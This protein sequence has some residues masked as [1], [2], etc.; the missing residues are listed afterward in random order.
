[1]ADIQVNRQTVISFPNDDIDDITT[2]IAVGSLV[3]DEVLW[4]EGFSIGEANANRF[5]AEV[6]NIDD[7]SGKDI[8]V[9]QIITSGSDETIEPLFTGRVD[10]CKR[11][12][13]RQD[14]ARKLVAYDA[15][16]YLSDKNVAEWW[17]SIFDTAPSITLGNM[18]KSLCTYVGLSYDSTQTLPNDSVA[19]TQTQQINSIKFIDVLKYICI[20]QCCTA[21]ISRTGAIEFIT[22]VGTTHT[23]QD[24]EYE[25]NNSEFE[26]YLVPAID[27]VKIA[28]SVND[29]EVTAGT[30]RK[31][32]VI[33]DNLLVLNKSQQDLQVIANVIL[34]NLPTLTYNPATVRMILSDHDVKVGDV[35]QTDTGKTLICE[36]ELSGSML[37]EQTCIGT[38]SESYDENS[39]DGYKYDVTEQELKKNISANETKYYRLAN[40]DAISV[41][42]N[43]MRRILSTRYAVTAQ[44]L[45]IFQGVVILDVTPI[46]ST[47]PFGVEIQYEVLGEIV[48]TFTPTETYIAGR[49]TFNLLYFW[50]S[51]A[52]VNDT[53]YVLLTTTNCAVSIGA[54]RIKAL[55]QGI[56]LL[57]DEVWD[58]YIDVEDTIGLIDITRRIEFI[59]FTDDLEV[60][61]DEPLTADGEETVGLID[62]T[63]RIDFI[64]FEDYVLVDKESLFFGGYTW[65]DVNEMLWAT[66]HD[67]YTW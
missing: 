25:V 30:G 6:Y 57:G 27:K 33:Q 9:Y 16:Y 32:I 13:M 19:I 61:I 58:G 59:S 21:N 29:V 60:W 8:Y 43:T 48:R 42:N 52:S 56:G 14:I 17:E 5:E 54:Y 55:M 51:E 50:D 11:N 47:Q 15:L 18:R 31:S 67:D 49:H 1:M 53:F 63:R 40:K 64:D 12:R 24:T 28:N 4:A 10:S 35:I 34:Q 38:G 36:N 7:I 37:I 41:G 66:V 44:C 45:V 62:I 39:T 65:G 2:G 23:Y 46:D 20:L 22:G 26:S 3:V